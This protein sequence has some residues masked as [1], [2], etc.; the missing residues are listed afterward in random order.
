MKGFMYLV[1]I[2]IATI[3]ILVSMFTLLSMSSAKTNWERSALE[4]FHSAFYSTDNYKAL[5]D[6]DA[7]NNSVKSPFAYGLSVEGTPPQNISVGCISCTDSQ[8]EWL[9]EILTPVWVNN[10]WINF[11]VSRST[12][13]DSFDVAVFIDK[14]NFDSDTAVQDYLAKGRPLVAITKPDYSMLNTFALQ[15]DDF[16]AS[17]PIHIKY[18]LST[19]KAARYFFGFGMN[20]NTPYYVGGG[21]G[22]INL[23][24]VS[25]SNDKYGNWTLWYENY[26]VNITGFGI[27]S[28]SI[29]KNNISLVSFKREND[30]FSLTH[31]DTDYWF[32][33]KKIWP[34][35]SGVIFQP[36]NV[37]FPF[38]NN[39]SNNIDP[40]VGLAN[41][42]KS[43]IGKDILYYQGTG[44][45]ILSAAAING[46]AAW[47]TK[48]TFT[49]EYGTLVKAVVAAAVQ[50]YT[51][52][53]AKPGSRKSI[54]LHR[55]AT[56]C[57]DMI[58]D[59]VIKLKIWYVV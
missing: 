51:L 31:N 41:T 27:L 56:L 14:T 50:N 29:S 40:R 24:S 13:D 11:S 46:T 12:L 19:S 42:V 18:N 21:G 34:D 15:L 30:T 2:A 5:S 49:H 59:I 6:K 28:V 55:L 7:F 26:T 9:R 52:K 43:K 36:L 58:E 45:Q 4:E 1:E 8:L 16:F 22:E 48:S 33:I 23:M 10:R 53:E 44:N 20:V 32:K 37:T 3:I 35:K 17:N 57:C 54:E 47:I 38:D 25:S 39:N